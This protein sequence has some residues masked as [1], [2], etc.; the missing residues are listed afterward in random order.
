MDRYNDECNSLN[1]EHRPWWTADFLILLPQETNGFIFHKNKH[2][3]QVNSGTFYLQIIKNNFSKKSKFY[4]VRISKARLSP[5]CTVE[6]TLPSLVIYRAI[7]IYCSRT[8]SYFFWVA[9]LTFGFSRKKNKKSLFSFRP[10][11]FFFEKWLR[12]RNCK[13]LCLPHLIKPMS[14]ATPRIWLITINLLNNLPFLVH[15]TV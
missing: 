3:V 14:L 6:D 2:L 7:L 8:L 12:P 10:L 15:L 1:L 4:R 5:S 13:L 11:T 9:E